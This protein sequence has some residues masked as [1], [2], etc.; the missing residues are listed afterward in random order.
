MLPCG[1]NTKWNRMDFWLPAAVAQHIP[2]T[3][4][5]GL[6][7]E[8]L[9]NVM[10]KYLRADVVNTYELAQ[11]FFACLSERHGERVQELLNINKQV[12]HVTWKM[13]CNGL[14][15]RP[16]EL[17]N[18]VDAC[19]EY[20][21]LLS[22]KVSELSGIDHITDTNLR[23][24]LFGVWGLK[25]VKKTKKTKAPSVDAGSLLKLHNTAE[26][27]TEA[28][29]FLGCYLSLKKYEKKLTSL[30]SYSNSRNSVGRVHPAFFI[31]GTKTVR[32]S[33]KNPNP[34]N[35]T[36]A[37]NPYEEDAPDIARWLEA[38][39]SMR[40]VFGP[41][42]GHW[43]LTADYPQ[44]QLRLNA[45]IT[46]EQEM[47][48]AFDRGWD[49]HD[50]VARRIF[51]VSDNMQPTKAQRRVAKNVNFGFVFGASP[52]KIEQ[53]AG[54]PGLW[55]TVTDLFPN[56]HAF[57]EETKRSIDET[58]FVITLGGYPL[59]LKEHIN[60]YT[61]E[62]EKAAHAG[63][64]YIVQG[65]EG[66]IVKRAMFLTDQYLT[67]YYPQGRLALQVHD[68]LLFETPIKPPKKHIRNLKSLMEQAAADYGLNAPVEVSIVT[69]RW[70]KEV[71]ISL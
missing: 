2:Q 11:H 40:S 61:G 9:Q 34:Q 21:G 25:P 55:D 71:S 8:M 64:N 14:W 41:P 18:A 52:W 31:T 35:I 42:A 33:A 44:L 24:L 7:T 65:A 1:T 19:H 39:P 37:G 28:H 32:I 5:P 70:D 23:E 20:I 54:I 17:Q 10:A 46:Q 56:A 67:D 36:K 27:G 4:H 48:D 43:W 30:T 68:E 57:I 29:E 22:N 69:H 45:F 12:E 16:V 63:V 6:K 59:E 26:V 60:K 51:N 15:V 13:E 62:L 47:M 38:S 66:V 50:F 53:T 58:G 3:R 49:A